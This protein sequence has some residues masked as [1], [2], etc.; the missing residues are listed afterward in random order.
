M[1][2][3]KILSITGLLGIIVYS[4]SFMAFFMLA[5]IN[6]LLS[7]KFVAYVDINKFGEAYI[8]GVLFTLLFIGSIYLIIKIWKNWQVLEE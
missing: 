5:F 8:E 6:G 4:I 1:K 3:N 2:I 7:K